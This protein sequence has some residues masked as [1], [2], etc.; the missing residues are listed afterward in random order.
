LI[1]AVSQL[2]KD[3]HLVIVGRQL[4]SQHSYYEKLQQRIQELNLGSRVTFAGWRS[5][6]PEILTLFD[7]FVLASVT[8]A[9]PIVVLEAMA[10]KCPV[11]ATNVGG[12]KEQI[13]SADYGWVVPPEDPERLSIAV[14][15]ALQS[16]SERMKRAENARKRVE[17]VFSLEACVEGHVQI[18]RAANPKNS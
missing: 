12:V 17:N 11:V 10:M 8:E 6:I 16:N 5:D 7:V 1:E 14:N 9:C 4:E 3:A 18:Y 15:A 2:E 13:P